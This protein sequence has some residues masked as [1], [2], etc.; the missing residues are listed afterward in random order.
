MKIVVD[1]MGGDF[2]P[3]AVVEGAVLATREFGFPV[4]LVG[5]SDAIQEELDKYED[6]KNLPIEVHHADEV[7]EMHDSPSKALRTKK[8]SSMKIGLDLVKEGEGEAFISAGNTGA[9]L[10]YSTIILRPLKGV[11]RPAIAIQLPTLQGSAILLDAGAN[12]DCKSNQLFQFGIM[13]HVYAKY[14]LGL[15]EPG[16]GLLSIGEEDGKGNEVTKEAFRWLSKSHIRFIGNVEA[17]EVYRGNADVIVCDGFTGNVALKISESLA[18]MIGTNLKTLFTS[19]IVPKMGYLM[20]KGRLREFKKSVDYSEAGGAPLLGVNGVVIIAHG[21]SNAKA[22]KNAILRA[23]EF[24]EKKV[25]QHI[26]EDIEY[27]LDSKG[28]FWQHIKEIVAGHDE[29]G[30][31]PNKTPTSPKAVLEE[32]EEELEPE[33][34]DE[35]P[36]EEPDKP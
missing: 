22:V 21:S 28:S 29:N 23:H 9:V 36:T 11:D 2:A 4:I 19:G 24:V 25:N 3:Q 18:E 35:T 26:R 8:K 30:G 7:V 15:D 14:I 6:A 1:A 20:L 27:N 12:V 31:V 34:T 5:L 33:T 17:K 13:G 32:S 16:V 10:A